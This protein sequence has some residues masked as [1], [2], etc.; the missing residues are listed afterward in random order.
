MDGEAG[1]SP[2]Y[3]HTQ[4]KWFSKS[5]QRH[6]KQVYIY[7]YIHIPLKN[8]VS[9]ALPCICSEMC[10]I[11]PIYTE[12]GSQVLPPVWPPEMFLFIYF[13]FSLPLP[14]RI[15]LLNSTLFD[16]PRRY[17]ILRGPAAEIVLLTLAP[18]WFCVLN[19]GAVRHTCPH[20]ACR[21]LSREIMAGVMDSEV[22][23]LSKQ[24]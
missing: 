21:P 13:Y 12:D 7:I 2:V 20:G 16:G 6:I 11:D 3:L 4:K 8:K 1:I 19:A 5:V 14:L 15:D 18:S 24:K 17:P 22:T 9:S 23:V 10:L